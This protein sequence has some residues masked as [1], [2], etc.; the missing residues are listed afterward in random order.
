MSISIPKP[1]ACTGLLFCLPLF[2]YAQFDGGDGGGGAQG[3]TLNYTYD[4][5]SWSPENPDGITTGE[6]T[7]NYLLISSGSASLS[8]ATAASQVEISPG[9]SLQANSLTLRDSVFIQADASGYGQYK[10]SQQNVRIQQYIA[11]TGWHNISM[12]VAGNLDQFG[13]VNTARSAGARNIYQWDAAAQ[14]WSDPVGASDGSSVA[15]SPGA[16]YLTFVGH[17][18]THGLSGVIDTLQTIDF[19][20]LMYTSANP[21]YR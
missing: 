14:N 20:G 11:H 6:S 21:D 9:A 3:S 15:N 17:T 16:G 4:G 1:L 13:A 19:S 5:S 7:V 10:G 12:P 8:S 18:A 2:T